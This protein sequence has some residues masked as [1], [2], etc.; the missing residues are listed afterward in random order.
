MVNIHL[1]FKVYFFDRFATVAMTRAKRHL[2]GYGD[3]RARRN[4]SYLHKATH[5]VWWA[6]HLLFSMEAVF[7]RIGSH[8][9][10]KKPTFGSQDWNEQIHRYFALILIAMGAQ[11]STQS[12][13]SSGISFKS[14]CCPT[15][16]S[17]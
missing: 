14:R 4:A 12:F 17:S 13:L 3:G 9:W 11:I 7:S 8:G 16:T 5:S 1:I 10:K 15:I 2:V 6:I